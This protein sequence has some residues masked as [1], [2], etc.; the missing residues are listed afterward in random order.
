MRKKN[1]SYSVSHRLL[2]AMGG[3]V[4]TQPTIG[5]RQGG[6]EKSGDESGKKRN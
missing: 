5:G 2:A 3:D 4:Y 6:E 1:V